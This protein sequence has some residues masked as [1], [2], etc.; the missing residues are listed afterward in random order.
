MW[1]YLYVWNARNMCVCVYLCTHR[2][3]TVVFHCYYYYD[4]LIHTRTHILTHARIHISTIAHMFTHLIFIHCLIAHTDIYL[5]PIFI[6]ERRHRHTKIS[7]TAL[8]SVCVCRWSNSGHLFVMVCATL[9]LSLTLCVCLFLLLHSSFFSVVKRFFSLI[10][11]WSSVIAKTSERPH[12]F[13]LLKTD[14]TRFFYHFFCSLL[15]ANLLNI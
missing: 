9:S 4:L 8:Y 7:V 15:S 3:Y 10:F 11:I 13:V 14:K 12:T 5:I 6:N 1:N 2:T